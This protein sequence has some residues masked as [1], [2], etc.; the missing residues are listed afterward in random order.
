MN[1]SVVFVFEFFGALCQSGT[2][3]RVSSCVCDPLDLHMEYCS[4]K[5]C[6][7]QQEV[8]KKIGLVIKNSHISCATD[9]LLHW[10]NTMHAISRSASDYGDSACLTLLQWMLVGVRIL[11]R[12]L[13]SK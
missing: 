3:R 1:S 4:H 9:F 2:G 12:M 11:S 8:K 10:T 7:T 6:W 13:Q 5:Y